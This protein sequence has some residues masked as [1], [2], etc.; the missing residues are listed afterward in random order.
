MSEFIAENVGDYVKYIVG[1]REEAFY[2]DVAHLQYVY[3]G[4]SDKTWKLIP[5]AFRN[6]YD[7]LNE[8]LYIKEF[9][10]ELPDQCNSLEYFDILVKARHYGIP[11]RLLDFTLNPLV[12]LFF[13][14]GKADEREGQD[15]C[16]SAIY[17]TGLFAEDDPGCIAIMHYLFRW[18]TG[19]QW[20]RE[21]SDALASFFEQQGGVYKRITAQVI[22]S[23]FACEKTKHFF[24][25][26]KM[27]N[28]RVRAQQ[29]VVAL[30]L[31]PL[32][33]TTRQ[34]TLPSDCTLG[35]PSVH[36]RVIIPHECK[37]KILHE[38]D[39]LGI[40]DSTL[41]PGLESHAKD[42]VRRIRHQNKALNDRILKH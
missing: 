24:V 23:V 38:L 37:Q 16:V 22:E 41:F 26:P 19:L 25:A 28:S 29:G 34:F 3:R 10:R 1:N 5:S 20:K 12:A 17:P 39:C 14:C 8:K 4:Q 42:I 40:N 31:T 6:D 32:S 11:T 35:E 21:D 9:V 36:D 30:Y 2:H 15:G 7:F 33:K 27:T 13:A 18:K